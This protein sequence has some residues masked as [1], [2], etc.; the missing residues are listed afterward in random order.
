MGLEEGREDHR[1][2]PQAGDSTM[3]RPRG[4]ADKVHPETAEDIGGPEVH[5][6]VVR[7]E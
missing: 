7:P 1:W 3:C 4:E 6:L 2:G 5:E